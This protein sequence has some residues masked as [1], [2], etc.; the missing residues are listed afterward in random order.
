MDSMVDVTTMN[1]DVE[2]FMAAI[3]PDRRPLFDRLHALILALYPDAQIRLSYGVP[4]YRAAS[5]WVALGYWKQ[6]VSLYTNGAHH[7][8]QFKAAHPRIK[9]GTGSI[10]LRLTDEFPEA[11]LREV[12]RHAIEHP[13]PA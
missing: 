9:T 5:G 8:M 12:I 7:L 3:P 10:N 13:K 6:G 1:T 2:R 11:A 4:T